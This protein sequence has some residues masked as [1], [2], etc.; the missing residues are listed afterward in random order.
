[1]LNCSSWVGANVMLF[2]AFLVVLKKYVPLTGGG[3]KDLRMP[4]P[5]A[6]PFAAPQT[7]ARKQ[8]PRNANNASKARR[9]AKNRNDRARHA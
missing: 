4:C 6:V 5:S 8:K 3:I 2:P 7:Q 1:M 9:D